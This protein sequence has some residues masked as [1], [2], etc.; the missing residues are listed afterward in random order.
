MSGRDPSTDEGNRI[1]NK[2]TSV[3]GDFTS[4]SIVVG[5]PRASGN[6]SYWLTFI[7]ISVILAHESVHTGLKVIQMDLPT[8]LQ[9]SGDEK[10]TSVP[11]I[12]WFTRI[13]E[14]VRRVL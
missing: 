5:V 12:N 4:C 10:S 7:I 11:E 6:L 9:N 2:W 13:C 8:Q 1:A 3:K 14:G